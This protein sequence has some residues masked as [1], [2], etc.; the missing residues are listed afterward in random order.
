MGN[1]DDSGILSGGKILLR[2]YSKITI[3]SSNLEELPENLGP[4]RPHQKKMA[5]Q[6]G[7]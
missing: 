2:K 6:R 4:S 1:S 5:T 3:P 7:T